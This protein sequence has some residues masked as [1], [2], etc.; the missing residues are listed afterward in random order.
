MTVVGRRIQLP[1]QIESLHDASKA[2]SNSEPLCLTDF[3]PLAKAKIP[4][5]GCEYMTTGAADELGGT[6][7]RLCYRRECGVG[8][9]YPEPRSTV[10]F[11]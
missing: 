4:S 10:D 9:N 7:P 6:K 2:D 8:R 3:E 5:M 1:S 11:L